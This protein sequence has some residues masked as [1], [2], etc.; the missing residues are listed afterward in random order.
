MRFEEAARL[1]DQ[2]RA[3]ERSLETQRVFMGDLADRDVLG[4]HREGPDLVFQ[5]L[6]MRG[7]K[8]LDSRAYPFSG[9]EFPGD[10]LLSSFLSLH[11][12]RHRPARRGAAPHRAGQRRRAGRG[13]VR[14]ART[15]R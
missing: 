12:E 14:A 4:I 5:V 11:Y 9:Q 7:G 8:L 13:A 3:V 10:E 15:A 6:S 1:R 2:L